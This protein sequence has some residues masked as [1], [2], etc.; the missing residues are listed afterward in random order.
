MTINLT[1]PATNGHKFVVDL[2]DETPPVP[3]DQIPEPRK[4]AFTRITA[5][6]EGT[7]QPL[8][9]P[10]LRERDERDPIL[11]W[12]LGYAR[13]IVVFHLLR[14][15]V[16]QLRLT[17]RAPAG[18]WR[19][20]RWVVDGVTD[21]EGRPLRRSAVVRDDVKDYMQLVRERNARV[22]HRGVIAGAMA[23]PCCC[24]SL[25]WRGG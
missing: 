16:Y 1:E 17:R 5:H 14:I 15:P 25:R 19:A 21:A 9:V 20:I 13:H 12:A 7:K 22:R 23:V 6:R 8:V 11:R 2:G 10:W 24:W 4:T 3:V 18:L